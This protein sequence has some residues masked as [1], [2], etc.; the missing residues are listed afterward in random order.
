[1]APSLRQDVEA[2]VLGAA[3]PETQTGLVVVLRAYFDESGTHARS[4][5]VTVVGVVATPKK[6]RA[7]T[8]LWWQTLKVAGVKGE[9]K[10][11]ECVRGLGQYEGWPMGTRR[12][13]RAQLGRLIDDHAIY[14][15]VVSM[16]RA[17]FKAEIVPHATKGDLWEDPYPWCLRA[18]LEYIAKTEKRA[19][20]RVA[21]VADEGH[22]Y[23]S[24]FFE[25]FPKLK[26]AKNWRQVFV[27]LT[28]AASEDYAPLQAAE[29]LVYEARH[30]TDQHVYGTPKRWGSLIQ[31][32]EKMEIEGG[33]FS[34]KSLRGLMENRRQLVE[35]EA[36]KPGKECEGA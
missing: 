1:V 34:G 28:A 32:F 20:R 14:A 21:C 25:Y 6:W 18:C 2:A 23:Q 22:G 27:S 10:S 31:C 8:R 15:S 9:F 3:F 17:D 26:Q 4:R 29:W 5:I 30:T 12:Q 36:A 19:G 11:D 35:R 7:F 16:L 24:R 13:L 33:N